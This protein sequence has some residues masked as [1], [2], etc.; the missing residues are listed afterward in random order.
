MNIPE[1]TLKKKIIRMVKE[2]FDFFTKRY[3]KKPFYYDFND[4]QKFSEKNIEISPMI[5]NLKGCFCRTKFKAN[6]F[7][8]FQ[9]R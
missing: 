8:F 7:Q 5:Q 4:E 6:I 3:K 1:V 2:M 9:Q